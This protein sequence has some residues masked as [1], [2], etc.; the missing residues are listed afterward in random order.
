MEIKIYT[1][2]TCGYC[3]QAKSFL[4]EKGA[5]FTEYD[6]SRD[7]AAAGELARLTGQMAVPVIVV[8][9]QPI[10]G[11]DRPRLEHLLAANGNSQHPHFGLQIADASRVSQRFGLI[12]VF[13]AFI[14]RV[15]PSSPG[16]KAGLR[17]GDIITELNFRP[18]NNA[19]ELE[20]ALSTLTAGSRV[21][22]VFLRGQQTLKSEIIL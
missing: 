9:G 19:D 14:G 12:P 1:T 3:H 15:A 22:I 4:A 21:M 2:P 13:G 11:F 20:N 10:I 7:Q 16:E 8:D 5:Q 17:Q 18:I 6:V